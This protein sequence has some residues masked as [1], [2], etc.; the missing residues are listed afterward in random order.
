MQNA[1]T[2][3]EVFTYE[4]RVWYKNKKDSKISIEY[5]QGIQI[6]FEISEDGLIF[7][8]D[9]YPM[10]GAFSNSKTMEFTR[11]TGG[12]GGGSTEKVSGKKF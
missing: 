1:T 3:A 12:L 7:N 9:Y 6:D 2:N 4:G 10:N 11:Y 5:R 8:D